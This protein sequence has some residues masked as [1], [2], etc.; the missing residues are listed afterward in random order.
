MNVDNTKTISDIL[1]KYEELGKN[2]QV[3]QDELDR[4]W[5][6]P[7]LDPDMSKSL[8]ELQNLVDEEA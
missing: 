3:L 1:R 8:I 4:N 5:V 2:Y 7:K 6:R